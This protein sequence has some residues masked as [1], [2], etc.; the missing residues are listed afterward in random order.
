MF[1]LTFGSYLCQYIEHK[2][3]ILYLVQVEKSPS[4]KKVFYAWN[5]RWSISF[6]LNAISTEVHFKFINYLFMCISCKQTTLSFVFV[7]MPRRKRLRLL[8]KE[9]I[10]SVY[11]YLKNSTGVNGLKISE[12]TPVS[13]WFW[14]WNHQTENLLPL[15]G[16]LSLPSLLKPFLKNLGGFI[17]A[18]NCKRQYLVIIL[19][20]IIVIIGHL[21]I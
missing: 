19:I 8:T 4:L 20:T 1:L 10:A 21:F 12:T 2:L 6:L 11:D 18:L 5:V 14:S 13:W 15:S 17:V 3:K 9:V 7:K 16:I